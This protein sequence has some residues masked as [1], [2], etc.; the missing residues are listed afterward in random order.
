M[1]A[2]NGV[3]VRC[4]NRVPGPYPMRDPDP[5]PPKLAPSLPLIRRTGDG[6]V[7][8]AAI[9]TGGQKLVYV[10]DGSVLPLVAAPRV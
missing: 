8:L 7:T 2:R 5:T 1:T 3:P 9:T 6:T 10:P 4:N